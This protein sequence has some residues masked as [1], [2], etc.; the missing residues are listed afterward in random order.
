MS[1]TAETVIE[2]PNAER[3][4]VSLIAEGHIT[5]LEHRGE[6]FNRRLVGTL[7]TSGSFGT[8]YH[9]EAVYA[10]DQIVEAYRTNKPIRLSGWVDTSPV[11]HLDQTC[12]VLA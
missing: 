2:S 1:A 11:S 3:D 8:L 7:R 4:E 10:E 5:S 12:R 9:F 6:G